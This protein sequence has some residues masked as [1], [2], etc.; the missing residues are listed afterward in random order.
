MMCQKFQNME[1]IKKQLSPTDLRVAHHVPLDTEPGGEEGEE[2]DD[3]EGACASYK[4]AHK[5]ACNLFR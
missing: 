2:D 4:N 3:S 5:Q 1:V